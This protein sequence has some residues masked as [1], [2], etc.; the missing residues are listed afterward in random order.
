MPKNAHPFLFNKVKNNFHINEF[1]G[2]IKLIYTLVKRASLPMNPLDAK[3]LGAKSEVEKK[4]IIPVQSRSR[5]QD[6]VEKP[7]RG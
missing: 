5:G 4:G 6:C 7:E 3:K 1:V 2:I